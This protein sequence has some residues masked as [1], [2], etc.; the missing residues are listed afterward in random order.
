VIPKDGAPAGSRVR[1]E[2]LLDEEDRRAALHEATA[3]GLRSTPKELP[4]IWLYDVRGSQ[5]FDEITR[6]PEYYPTRRE[7]EILDRRAGEI[8]AITRA[9]T[10]VE[11]GSGTSE[12][13]RLLLDA[14]TRE[15]GL[16]CFMPLDVSEEVLVESARAIAEEYPELQVHAVVG[17]FERHLPAIADGDRRLVA[18]LGSTIGNLGPE[19]RARLLETAARAIGGDGALLLGLDLVKDPARIEAAYNDGA[20]LSEAFQRNALAH[21]DR[22]L[23]STFA[24]ADFDYT[25]TWDPEHEW[26]EIGF[27]SRKAQVVRV[28]ALG[29]GVSFADGEY[30]RAEVSAKFRREG[31]ETELAHAGLELHRWWTDDGGD[32]AVTLARCSKPV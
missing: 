22:E 28:P 10:L 16:T 12:K 14:L 13:T 18:L 1:V 2:V 11:L 5:I 32:F 25:A 7:R 30:F 26:M 17:D 21:A 31:V 4:A 3:R 8:A 6:L 20:G 23:D 15:G 9:R 29:M 24:R 27:R 19:A